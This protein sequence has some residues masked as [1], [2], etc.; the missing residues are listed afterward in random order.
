MFK[1]CS[2]YS[3]STGNSL[4]VETPNTKILIDAGESAKKIVSALS[5]ICVDIENIDAILVTH[6]HSDHVKGLG[7]LS[8][9]Y[10]IPVYANNGTWQAMPVQSSKIENSNKRLF[11]SNKLFS[12]GELKIF[13]FSIPHDAAEPCGFNIYYNDYLRGDFVSIRTF[14]NYISLI[15]GN[16][17]E[18]CGMNGFCSNQ[19][20][21]EGDGSV[22]PCDFYC[23]D[24]WLLG[25]INESSFKQMY[26]T[27]K[28]VE[29][30]KSSF[31][32]DDKCK[33]LS[34][35]HI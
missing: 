35:I 33:E 14:D 3:G 30:I 28:C 31:K 5:N 11:N 13:P 2:L 18:Q 20:V 27:S 24:E 6:E 32:L 25:N 1:F 15:N 21:V 7:T 9:K 8:K 29:F 4:F 19:F 26:K 23:T 22:Y 34:L 10:N 17:A 16:N 12:V